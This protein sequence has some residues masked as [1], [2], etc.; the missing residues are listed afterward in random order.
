MPL[1][2]FYYVN[3]PFDVL[4]DPKPNRAD[5]S[6]AHKRHQCALIKAHE[7]FVLQNF[8]NA[9]NNACVLLDRALGL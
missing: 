6:Y 5:K 8:L 1:Y 2:I 7:A 3:L 9:V 4:E